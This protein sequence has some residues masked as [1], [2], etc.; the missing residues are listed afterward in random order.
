MDYLTIGLLCAVLLLLVIVLLRPKKDDSKSELEALRREVATQLDMQSRQVA[1]TLELAARQTTDREEARARQRNEFERGLLDQINGIRRENGLTLQS[2]MEQNTKQ[3][4]ALR[5]QID[6][7]LSEAITKRMNESF[8]AINEQMQQVQRGFEEMRNLSRGVADLNRVMSSVKDRGTWGESQ[9]QSLLEQVLSPNQYIV[10]C[11]LFPESREKV[12]FAVCMPNSRGE[13]TLLPI[14]AKF[15]Q[16]SYLRLI[17]A[18]EETERKAAAAQLAVDVRR[19]AASIAEKYIKTPVTTQFGILYLPSEGLYAQVASNAAL[20][21][22]L[23]HK[24]SVIVTGPTTLLGLLNIINMGAQAM[25]IE[26]NSQKIYGL[27]KNVSRE[28]ATFADAVEKTQTHIRLAQEDF[29]KLVG[30]RTRKMRKELQAVEHFADS[31]GNL[32]SGGLTDDEEIE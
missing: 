11:Q 28:F 14:D 22:E 30:T 31:P 26:Q 24:Y 4:N 12:D 18:R 20:V 13:V 15:P 7:R 5:E 17:E 29:E 3:G 27:L 19:Q 23:H 25:I 32:L 6:Q 2:M 1:G 21:D 16:E 8:V 10:Q 9:L